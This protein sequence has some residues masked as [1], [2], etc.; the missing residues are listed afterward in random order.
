MK[1]IMGEFL[2]IGIIGIGYSGTGGYLLSHFIFFATVVFAIIG[3]LATIKW[4]FFG[5]KPK[6][7]AGQR[8]LRT[9]KFD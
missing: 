9:G 6:E 4:L 1:F 7:T 2:G 8:W 3:L 5:R